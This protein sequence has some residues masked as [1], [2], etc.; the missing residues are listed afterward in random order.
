MNA[1]NVANVV[2]GTAVLIINYPQPAPALLGGLLLQ[3][4]AEQQ[5]ESRSDH[6]LRIK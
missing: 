5:N 3:F 2:D 4:N 1:R 6:L